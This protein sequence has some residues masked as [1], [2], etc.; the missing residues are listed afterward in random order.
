MNLFKKRDKELD[1][2]TM[3]CPYCGGDILEFMEE[4]PHCHELMTMDSSELKHDLKMQKLHHLSQF[5][6]IMVFVVLFIVM[7]FKGN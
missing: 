1:A 2:I 6:S 7:L 3:R 4:C 5:I